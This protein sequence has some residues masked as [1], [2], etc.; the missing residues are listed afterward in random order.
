MKKVRILLSVLALCLV[1]VMA[2]FALTSCFGPDEVFEIIYDEDGNDTGNARLVSVSTRGEYTVPETWEGRPVTEIG[3]EAFNGSNKMTKLNIPSS[4]EYI[5]IQSLKWFGMYL[6]EI[7][8]IGEGNYTTIDGILYSKGGE[9]LLV[10]PKAHRAT[11]YVTPDCLK[12]IRGECTISEVWYLEEVYIGDSVEEIGNWALNL[13]LSNGECRVRKLSIPAKFLGYNENDMFCVTATHVKE[14]VIT[15]GYEIPDNALF[16]FDNCVEKVVLP[17]GVGVI[18]DMFTAQNLKEV[19][20]PDS[21]EHI[22]KEFCL[23]SKV[24]SITLP[25]GLKTL[26]RG[27]FGNCDYL[28]E[29]VIPDS[30]EVSGEGWILGGSLKRLTAS[31]SV[32]QRVAFDEI[33]LEEATVT[34]IGTLIDEVWCTEINAKH[35]V[36]GENVHSI[37]YARIRLTDNVNKVTILGNVSEINGDMFTESAVSQIIL[38]ET[39]TYINAA[40]VAVRQEISLV[41]CHK[42]EQ[43]SCHI[44]EVE[45]TLP[46]NITVSWNYKEPVEPP[47]QMEGEQG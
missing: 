6:E 34:K 4:V 15:N 3:P 8:Y 31:L 39:V 42:G 22:G 36:F 25:E 30:V 28:N 33:E 41:I 12:Y 10:Y 38:P 17:E 46:E 11:A 40:S 19:N 45:M 37:P 26:G 32:M 20:V 14:L 24:E 44:D 21:V 16:Q 47:C 23:Y 27:S 1:T 9:E 5:N 35:I 29:L 2:A 7:H 18:G 13:Q 43:S